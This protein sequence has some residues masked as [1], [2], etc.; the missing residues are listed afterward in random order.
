M[1]AEIKKRHYNM[2][3][4]GRKYHPDEVLPHF[5]GTSSKVRVNFDGHPIKMASHRYWT[6]LRKGLKCVTCGIEGQYFRKERHR[7]TEEGKYHFNLYAVDSEGDEVLITKDH[8]I[9]KSKGGR[10]HISNYQTMCIVCNM[11]KGADA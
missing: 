8:V 10:N 1:C 7:V 6:F 5:E 11:E 2:V 3:R 4:K 9:P